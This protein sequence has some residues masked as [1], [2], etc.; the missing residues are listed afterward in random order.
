MSS[1]K[2]ETH[3]AKVLD[4]A[5]VAEEIKREVAAEVEQLW[6]EYGVRPSLVAVR[7]GDD[8]ASEVYVRNK[9][10][11]SDALGLSSEHH[12]LAAQTSAAQ[13]LELVHDLNERDDVDGILVQL[14]LPSHIE[15]EPI[16]EAI[17]PAKDVDGFHPLNVGRLSLGQP[18]L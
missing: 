18:A 9:V 12:A 16:I 15:S 3:R 13:L 11:A 6:R 4:R 7:V 14:P 2:N 10:R 8:A 5:A 17:D 1:I